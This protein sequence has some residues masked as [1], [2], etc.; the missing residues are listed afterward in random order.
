MV[1]RERS[2]GVR[3]ASGEETAGRL[4][5]AVVAM[6]IVGPAAVAECVVGGEARDE[7]IAD[8]V[9]DDHHIVFRDGPK[10][11]KKRSTVHW[12]DIWSSAVA[13]GRGPALGVGACHGR[14]HEASIPVWAAGGA[15]GW[16]PRSKVSMMIMRPPQLGQG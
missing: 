6:G 13:R 8:G 14:R 7:N 3:E 10:D 5:W 4:G 1:P 16:A 9:P 15:R 11:G 2:A 12:R